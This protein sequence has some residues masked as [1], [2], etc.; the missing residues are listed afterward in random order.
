MAGEHKDVLVAHGHTAAGRR[1]RQCLPPTGDIPATILRALGHI[2]CR[3]APLQCRRPV[4]VC[5]RR[6]RR[7]LVVAGAQQRH[8][9][10]VMRLLHSRP[11]AAGW[12]CSRRWRHR[13]LLSTSVRTRSLQRRDTA[14]SRAPFS[15]GQHPADCFCRRR[16]RT[17]HCGVGQVSPA[18]VRMVIVLRRRDSTASSRLPTCRSRR[19]PL[20]SGRRVRRSSQA[21]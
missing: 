12:R 3:P 15:S 21:F 5:R 18:V 4:A 16:R 6:W 19:G 1:L 7:H 17:G 2:P 8:V 20:L 13:R 14:A 9:N 10:G 11:S